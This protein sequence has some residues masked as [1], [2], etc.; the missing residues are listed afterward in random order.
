MVNF[1]RDRIDVALTLLLAVAVV[2]LW[3]RQIS[4]SFWVDE[5]VTVFVV[6][7]GAGDPSLAIAPQVPKSS[8]Y[9]VAGMA[10]AL[11]GTREAGY[12]LPS[13]LFSLGMLWLVARLAARLIHPHAAWFAV[14]ACFACKALNWEAPDARPYAM[15]F[16][17]MAAAALFLIRWLD[18]GR[19]LDAVA[20]VIF[21]ALIW[22]IQLI[23]WPVYIAL[24]LYAVVRLDRRE[25]PVTWARAGLVFGSLGVLLIPVLAEAILVNRHAGAHVVVD[26]PTFG[27]LLNALQWKMMLEVASGALI[28]GQLARWG[29]ERA[30]ERT[31]PEFSAMILTGA[32]WLMPPLALFVFSQATGN[33]VFVRRYYSIALPGAALAAT[34]LAADLLPKRYWKQAAAI[35]GLGVVAWS[36][37]HAEAWPGSNWRS[38]AEA[39]N[40]LSPGTPVIAPSPFI[41]AKVPNWR[42]DYPLP[43]F[44]YAHL[45]VY[46]VNQQM[47]LFPFRESPEAES[48]AT[49]LIPSLVE[50]ARFAIYGGDSNVRFW[51][52]WFLAHAEFS[53]WRARSLGSFGDVE[54]LL[55]ERAQTTAKMT[56]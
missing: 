45:S 35:L 43:G 54:A 11:F 8:Y 31:R 34:C 3:A 14:F 17:A 42:P 4:S 46:P 30:P 37:W 19:V 41:E 47:L 29:R 39:L 36:G 49:R 44:L 15:G 51:K 6:H 12:R 20:F 32:W 10:D 56:R 9:A 23:F 27:Q 16:C 38:A 2:F 24:F 5:M 21:A 48:Y 13:I 7:Q 25:T 26:Q 18:S 53:R 55:L 28:V 22:R 52:G 33:S 50:S 40:Q 1:V